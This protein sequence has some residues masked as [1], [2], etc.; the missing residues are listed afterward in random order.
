MECFVCTLDLK[1]DCYHRYTPEIPDLLLPPCVM[2]S[3]AMALNFGVFRFLPTTHAEIHAKQMR[4]RSLCAVRRFALVSHR[5]QIAVQ[6]HRTNHGYFD[7]GKTRRSPN[8]VPCQDQDGAGS[9]IPGLYLW[10]LLM[11]STKHGTS[12]LHLQAFNSKKSITDCSPGR[13]ALTLSKHNRCKSTNYTII[14][15]MGKMHAVVNY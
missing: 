7:Y 5:A 6:T 14:R 1:L 15:H 9:G 3:S 4:S 10:L 12:I 11:K 13:L 8:S 2:A